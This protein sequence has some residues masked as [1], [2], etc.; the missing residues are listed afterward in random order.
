MSS[1]ADK[2]VR[3]EDDEHGPVERSRERE[4]LFE[5]TPIIIT[6]GSLTIESVNVDFSQF[7]PNGPRKLQHP[8]NSKIFAV[9]IKDGL[10]INAP[11]RIVYLPP[12][13][14]KFII[15]VSY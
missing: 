13:D 6:G 3:R 10:D 14:G 12:A 1:D 5:T 15:V 8:R 2:T 11:S 4:K 7:T 9:D